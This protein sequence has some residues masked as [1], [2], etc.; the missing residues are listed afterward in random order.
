MRQATATGI[1]Q[2][3]SDGSAR[4]SFCYASDLSVVL[5]RLLLGEPRHDIYNVGCRAGTASIA[6]VAHV[7]DTRL[8]RFRPGAGVELL[9]RDHTLAQVE[10]EM[11]H[12]SEEEVTRGRNELTRD[13]GGS[14]GPPEHWVDASGFPVAA[15]DWFLLCTDGVHGVLPT[16]EIAARFPAWAVAEADVVADAILAEVV[17]RGPADNATLVVVRL[18]PGD[19]CP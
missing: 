9:T 11:F 12:R 16:K 5:F 8:Y 13:L 19:P 4:R 10:R 6:E 14:R 2:L 3:T 15:G 18:V 1:I 17:A 7:G